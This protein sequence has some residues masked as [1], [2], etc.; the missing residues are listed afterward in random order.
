MTKIQKPKATG[1]EINGVYFEPL[2]GVQYKIDYILTAEMLERKEIYN[3]EQKRP[4]TAQEVYRN[5]MQ[6]DLF[7]LVMFGLQRP[8]ANHPFLVKACYE[9]QDGPKSDTLDLWAREHWKSTIITLA[10]NI[11]DILNNPEERI[12]IFSYTR[13]TA[14]VFFNELKQNLER[15]EFLLR[16]FPDILW[17]DTNKAPEWSEEGISVK[18][19]SL[20][21]ERT[22]E[23]WGLLSGMPT[24]R[25]FTKRVYDD[26]V[27][28]DLVSNPKLMQETKDKFDMSENVGSDGDRRRVIGT[29]YHHDDVLVYLANQK[30]SDGSPAWHIRTKP[31]TVDGTSTGKP[32]LLSQEKID[33]LK[34]NKRQFNMQQLL[35]PTPKEDEELPFEMIREVTL[36]D[37]PARM[38]K[39]MV[40]DPAKG[41]RADNKEPDS[42]AMWVVGVDPYINDVGAS[43]VFI[44]DGFVGVLPW[45]EGLKEFVRIY[46]RNGW[47]HRLGVE[48]VGMQTTVSQFSAA[49]RAKGRA[50]TEDNKMIVPL[51]PG[52]RNKQMRIEANLG[53]PLRGGFIYRLDTLPALAVSSLK[54]EMEKYP[55]WKDDG[56]DGLAYVW[57]L[58]PDYKF[59]KY[60]PERKE[61]KKKSVWDVYDEMS[62]T[63]DSK[64]GWM[65]S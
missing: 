22:V 32:V 43:K 64:N 20:A 65:R 58:L 47:I 36:K 1:V 10:E 61:Q 7:A 50:V 62:G 42:W 6:Q 18:R 57:D 59:G 37:L 35:D 13:D 39:F 15:N 48:E 41:K 5:L 29:Y 46:L 28:L 53:G 21:K 52:K 44:L 3:H 51:K 12:V 8:A 56:I 26:I 63:A 27:T 49:L 4:A 55:M 60:H 2:P 40:V 17:E 25:H 33:R 38:F 31:A 14:K 19:K 16:L 45:E 34:L 24:A 30:K 23:A 54:T 9:V 11:Q